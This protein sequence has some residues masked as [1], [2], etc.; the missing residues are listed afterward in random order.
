MFTRTLS[1]LAAVALSG[2]AM[3]VTTSPA[4]AQEQDQVVVRYADLDL[5]TADGNARFEQRLRRASADVCG[6]VTVDLRISG[7]V[8]ACQANA[9]ANAKADLQIA[10][11]KPAGGYRVVALRTD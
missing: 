6:D 10:M 4:A 3:A 2:A 7:A 9:I 1:A 8:K 5:S 11:A